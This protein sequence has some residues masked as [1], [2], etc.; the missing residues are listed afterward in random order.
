MQIGI[1]CRFA[2]T[3]SGLGRYTRE[4]VT[5]LLKRNDGIEYAL[6]VQ[7]E[8]EPWLK[9]LSTTHYTLQTTNYSH[10]S[11]AEQIMLPRAIAEANID[12]FFSP[13]FN[14]PLRCHVPF[15]VTIHDL[16]LHSFPHE[17]PLWKCL[18]YRLQMRHSIRNSAHIIAVSQHTADEIRKTYSLPPLSGSLPVGE[19]ILDSLPL[20]CRPKPWRRLRGRVRERGAD[21]ISIIHEGISSA[22]SPQSKQRQQEVCAKYRLQKPFFLYVGSNKDHKNVPI[23]KKAAHIAGVSLICVPQSTG[24]IP[25]HD[26]P[27]LYSAATAFVTASIAE[28]FCLPAVEALAC[29]CP[30]IASN[31]SAIPEVTKWYATL[32]EPTVDAFTQAMKNPPPRPMPIRLYDW[33]ESAEKTADVF[34]RVSKVCHPELDEGRQTCPGSS[35]SP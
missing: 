7:S 31:R 11:L 9:N 22:F 12:L 26:L 17:A 16:I 23:L 19:R 32:I 15:I 20:A 8:N 4:L 29:G 6:F 28:G 10:Y 2:A 27:A 21:K 13:H 24:N 30:V 25:D 33:K 35:G 5:H 14:V 18:A 1:D 34:M 3:P